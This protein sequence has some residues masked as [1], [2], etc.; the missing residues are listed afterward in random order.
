ML[1]PGRTIAYTV[2]YDVRQAGVLV[3]LIP[4]GD[5]LNTLVMQRTVHP[6]DPHSGQISFPGGSREPQDQDL[7]ATAVR[8]AYEETGIRSEDIQVLGTLAPLYIPVSKFEI[9]PVMAFVNQLPT[10][11]L[12]QD[13][14]EAAFLISLKQLRE[15]DSLDVMEWRGRNGDALRE[16]PYYNIIPGIPIWGATAMILAEVTKWLEIISGSTEMK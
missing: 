12:S 4:D 14:S 10:I 3:T 13:E 2:P 16:I 15:Q 7:I 6:D 8:E 11:T 5:D 9:T 1:P